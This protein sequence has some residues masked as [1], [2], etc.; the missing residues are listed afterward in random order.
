[1][2]EKI[3]LQDKGHKRQLAGLKARNLISSCR[4]CPNYN[5]LRK[6]YYQQKLIMKK[7]Q[8]QCS[9][10]NKDN[11]QEH[12]MIHLVSWKKICTPK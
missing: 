5:L 6:W 12:S 11:A 7:Q 4:D 3:L 9:R 8:R 10:N 2:I 1:M